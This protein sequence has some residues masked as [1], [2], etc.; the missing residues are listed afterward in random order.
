MT[1]TLVVRAQ[2]LWRRWQDP[3]HHTRP[4]PLSQALTSPLFP[5]GPRWTLRCKNWSSCFSKRSNKRGSL[6]PEVSLGL[7]EGQRTRDPLLRPASAPV[8]PSPPARVLLC[9]PGAQLHSFLAPELG[10]LHL[11]V[12][13]LGEGQRARGG[14]HRG[15]NQRGGV[16]LR[17]GDGVTGGRGGRAGQPRAAGA[18]ALS[19]TGMSSLSELLPPL[20]IV[21]PFVCSGSQAVEQ[22]SYFP[23][24]V[25]KSGG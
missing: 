25:C 9:S 1:D 6:R 20:S 5:A 24:R 10:L 4:R 2:G 16:D 15:G 12:D 17:E 23:Q 8:P 13:Q 11:R 3:P 7:V 18:T 19:P 14:H 22:S 21:I